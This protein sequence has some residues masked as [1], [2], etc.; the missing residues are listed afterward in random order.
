MSN[1]SFWYQINEICLNDTYTWL[2]STMNFDLPYWCYSAQLSPINSSIWF[3]SVCKRFWFG[4]YFRFGCFL[5]PYMVEIECHRHECLFLIDSWLTIINQW[6]LSS[7]F[8]NDMLHVPRWK[9]HRHEWN[10]SPDLLYEVVWVISFN[11]I[12]LQH[13]ISPKNENSIWYIDRN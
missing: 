11:L 12:Q 10:C 5:F 3:G 4:K 9:F 13:R 8:K 7:L 6:F 2:L 1:K